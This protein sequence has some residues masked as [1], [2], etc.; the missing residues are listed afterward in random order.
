MLPIYNFTLIL[1][2]LNTLIK[3]LLIQKL[4]LAKHGMFSNVY[5]IEVI[6]PYSTT[7]EIFIEI[8]IFGRF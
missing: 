1:P 4:H 2:L 3:M 5:T 7:T 8:Q 6:N